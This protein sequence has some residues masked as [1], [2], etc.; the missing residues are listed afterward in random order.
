MNEYNL[1]FKKLD[2]LFASDIVGDGSN[3]IRGPFQTA[4]TQVYYNRIT[5]LCIRGYGEIHKD[6]Y[7]VL[8]QLAQESAAGRD[9]LT[10]SHLSTQTKKGEPTK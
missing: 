10:I 9:R 6:F 3:D 7:K 1:K 4:Q 8:Q 5:P 2:I